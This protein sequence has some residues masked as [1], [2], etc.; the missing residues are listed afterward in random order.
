ME[1]RKITK[2]QY[3]GDKL[4]IQWEQIRNGHTDRKSLESKVEPHPHFLDALR[5]LDK[6]LCV[7]AE[8]PQNEDE[9]KRH[10]IHSVILKYDQDDAGN[11]IMSASIISERFMQTS[12][13]PMKIA[14][15]MKPEQST[16][17]DVALDSKTVERIDLLIQEAVAY[18]EG[19]RLDLF[20]QNEGEME[21]AR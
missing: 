10:D 19:K 1:N 18:L 4:L 20:A 6:P 9:Y 13:E 3:K 5:T 12:P 14:T 16:G 21:V 15:P 8:L 17:H 2:I 7:E 11:D